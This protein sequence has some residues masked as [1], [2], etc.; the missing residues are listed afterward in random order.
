MHHWTADGPNAR[1]ITHLAR[2]MTDMTPTA[3]PLMFSDIFRGPL[4]ALPSTWGHDRL[5]V[6]WGILENDHVGNCVDA[7]GEHEHMYWA[8][9]SKRP[10]PRFTNTSMRNYSDMLAAAP[11]GVPYDP[12]ARDKKGHNPTDAGLNPIT[13]AEW[14]R[15]VGFLDDNGDRHKDDAYAGIT[16]L[17]QAYYTSYVLGV[18]GCGFGMPMTA[19]HEFVENKVWSDTSKAAVSGHYVPLVGRNS[20]GLYV[21]ISWG[22]YQAA[23]PAWV[24]KYFVGA[25]GYVNKAY[26]NANGYTPEGLDLAALE[27]YLASVN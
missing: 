26:L 11:N 20:R 18:C 13:A 27:E 25:C 14:R 12:H 9:T 10:L 5:G 15:T 3:A 16:D 24:E 22:H 6:I 1:N 2:G 21:F 8:L 23:T 17:E 4:P 19:E 7:G